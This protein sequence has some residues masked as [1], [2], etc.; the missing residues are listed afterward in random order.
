VRPA[1]GNTFNV[2]ADWRANVSAR[3]PLFFESALA[4]RLGVGD[5]S[6]SANGVESRSTDSRWPDVDVSY[7]KLADAFRVTR[8]IKSPQLRTSWVR[9]NSTD[10]LGSNTTKVGHSQSDDF[11]P[12]ISLRG[13]LKNGTAFDLS[14]NVRNTRREVYQFGTSLQTDNNTDMNFNLSR[15]YTQ[16]QKVNILGKTSTVRSSVSLQLATTYSHRSGETRVPG[17]STPTRLVN[18][19]RLSVTGT[20]TYGFSS[21]VSGSAV[22]GFSQSHDHA[23]DIVRRSI[24]VELRAQFGF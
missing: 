18:E 11:H 3:I 5:H 15:S 19:S 17:I 12:L 1:A 10:Y 20:G 4:T 22:L 23:V 9:S 6:G 14:T 2:G 7:G 8:F 21:T 16:G 13:N 24:R